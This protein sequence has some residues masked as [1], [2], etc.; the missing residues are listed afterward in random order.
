[1]DGTYLEISVG[2]A[3]VDRIAVVLVDEISVSRIGGSF[4]PTISGSS[5]ID[6]C[7]VAS[8]SS[9]HA[10]VRVTAV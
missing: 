5:N 3:D 2:C 7:D 6:V 4:I 8:R 9:R 1:M 10:P